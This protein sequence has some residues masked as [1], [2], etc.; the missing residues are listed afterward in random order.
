MHYEL[1]ASAIE[2]RSQRPELSAKYD[3]MTE[4]ANTSA[5]SCCFAKLTMRKSKTV[6]CIHSNT[7]YCIHSNTLYCIHSNTFYCIHSNI[8]GELLI[9][10][11]KGPGWGGAS[12]ESEQL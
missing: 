8:S 12:L 7:V 11:P 1:S 4:F 2:Y 3:V 10:T 9:T 6:Y 5:Q